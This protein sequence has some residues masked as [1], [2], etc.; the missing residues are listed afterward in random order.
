MRI[1]ARFPWD[2]GVPAEVANAITPPSS[3]EE[4]GKPK[5]KVFGL[6]HK[7][8]G[9]LWVGGNHQWD[10]LVREVSSRHWS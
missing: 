3:S 9:K 10:Q 5:C 1:M 7:F 4:G 6:C 8:S 2:L